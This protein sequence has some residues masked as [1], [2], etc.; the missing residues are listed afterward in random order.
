MKKELFEKSHLTHHNF[1]KPKQQKSQV[2]GK[3]EMTHEN[4]IL[5]AE[6]KAG[7]QAR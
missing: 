5:R 7:K 2:N 1:D 6:A 4:R 3:T